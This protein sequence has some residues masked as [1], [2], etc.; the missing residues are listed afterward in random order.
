M[1]PGVPWRFPSIVGNA[2]VRSPSSAQ[3]FSQCF[4]SLCEPKNEGRGYHNREERWVFDLKVASINVMTLRDKEGPA[5]N[6]GFSG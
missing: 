1:S 5:L 6:D 3:W 2:I 4:D